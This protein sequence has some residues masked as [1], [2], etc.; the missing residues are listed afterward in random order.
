MSETDK[1]QEKQKTGKDFQRSLPQKSTIAIAVIY[2]LPEEY[3]AQL[4]VEENAKF[5]RDSEEVMAELY[6]MLFAKEK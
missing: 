5:Y 2:K 6:P 1:L 3:S 4:S